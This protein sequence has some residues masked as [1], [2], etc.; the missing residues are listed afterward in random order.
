MNDPKQ[1]AETNSS[2]GR[3]RGAFPATRWTLIRR[4]SDKG[5]PGEARAAL[6]DLCGLYWFPLYAYAR[7]MGHPPE[8]A[9]DLTQ[10]YF[11][12]LLEK[13]IFHQARQ[14]KGRLRSFLLVTFKRFI[15]GQNESARAQKRGG[16]APLVSIDTEEAEQRYGSE[17]AHSESADRLFDRRWALALLD[18]VLAALRDEYAA[19]GKADVFE[20]LKDFL[21]WNGADE[22][23]ATAARALGMT[24]N[25]VRVS[26]FRM[27]RRYGDLLRKHIAETVDSP[28]QVA[29]EI[30]YLMQA[31]Q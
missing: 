7:G 16:G 1:V 10:G 19:S 17:I 21:A 14:E 4:L 20:A 30:D 3:V 2:P 11:L 9:E 5:D 28:A 13:E 12:K 6:E 29:D 8:N 15:Q 25:Y 27:R 23:Q 31:L 24:E 18:R 22:R 26:V